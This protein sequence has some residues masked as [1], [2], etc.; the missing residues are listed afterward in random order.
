MEL[1]TIAKPYAQ[2][3]FEIAEQSNSVLGWSDFLASTTVI[4]TDKNT[5]TFIASPSK[6]KDQKFDLIS[7]LI[8]RMTSK[9]LSKQE[10]AFIHLILNNDRSSAI[11]SIANAF[12]A[13]VSNANK[14]KNFKVISAYALSEDEQ[15]AIVEDLTSKHK[16]SVSVETEIDVTLKGG[17]IIKE[18]DK[19]IDTSIKAKV[20]ALSVSLSVN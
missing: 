4:M 15:K 7:A 16:T 2:A 6:N 14:S 20:D 10:A 18:G 8:T 3:I 11:S 17:V 1:S 19:V 9:D 12:E 13:T 5:K